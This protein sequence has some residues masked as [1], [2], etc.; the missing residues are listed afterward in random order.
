M[1]AVK[2]AAKAIG[3]GVA[4]GATFLLGVWSE[5][6]ALNEAFDAMTGVQWLGLVLSIA[7]AYGIIYRV[8]NG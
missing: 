5:S 8:P 1:E 3:A 2:S 7:G 4:A 6:A